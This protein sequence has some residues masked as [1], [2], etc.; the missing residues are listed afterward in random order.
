M[1]KCQTFLSASILAVLLGACG[2][3]QNNQ[4][5]VEDTANA[6]LAQA[7]QTAADHNNNNKP[8]SAAS[9]F[10]FDYNPKAALPPVQAASG[11]VPVPEQGGR[12]L[13]VSASL[14]FETN[15]VRKAADALTAA[16]KKHGGFVAFSQIKTHTE[17]SQRYRQANGDILK[18]T[19]YSHIAD[20]EVR[21]P[22]NNV[23]AFWDE[24]QQ[25]IVFLNSYVMRSE[26]L[27]LDLRRKALEADRQRQITSNFEE[28]NE[29]LLP[30]AAASAA[31]DVVKND[32]K[33][34]IQY[35]SPFDEQAK[36]DYAEIQRDYWNDRIKLATIF[37]RFSQPE[38]VY[39]K[40]LPNPEAVDAQHK[41]GFEAML[42][43]MF[44]Q[45]WSG[46]LGVVLFFIGIWPLALG[47][48]LVWLLWK[49][50]QQS[51]RDEEVPPD[52]EE[53]PIPYPFDDDDD[54]RL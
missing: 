40:T 13:V 15:N 20:M 8:L 35:G 38:A 44:Q 18:A 41:P 16:A 46:F 1:K 33:P 5:Y 21:V 6:P 4:D 27:M 45:G 47:V 51:G 36:A 11:A 7:E 26:D 2:G 3:A 43:P 12:K 19:F 49:R 14:E 42:T 9:S 48:P 30:Q 50:W 37:M 39:K 54:D 29:R 53:P 32:V 23:A 24:A 10:P 34:I 28:A 22:Y 52:D 31:S 25:H 17:A